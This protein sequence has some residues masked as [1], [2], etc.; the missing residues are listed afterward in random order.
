MMRRMVDTRSTEAGDDTTRPAPTL[1][2]TVTSS[3]GAAPAIERDDDVD[4]CGAD[5]FPASDAPSWWSGK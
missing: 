4:L 2:T 3:A 5:S 1:A